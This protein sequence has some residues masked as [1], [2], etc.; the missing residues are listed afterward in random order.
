MAKF[1]GKSMNWIQR[2]LS[3]QEDVQENNSN[4]SGSG[5]RKQVRNTYFLVPGDQFDFTLNLHNYL[6][7]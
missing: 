5:I 1:F 6:Y 2:S 7:S 3:D 4:G